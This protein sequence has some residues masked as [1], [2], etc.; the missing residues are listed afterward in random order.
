MTSVKTKIPI[1][2]GLWRDSN[3]PDGKPRLVGSECKNCGELFFPK[4]ENGTCANCQ[5]TDL[6]DVEF[7]TRGRVYS[8][9]VVMQRPPMYYQGEVPYALGFV[10]LPEGIRIETLFTECDF[11]RLEIG[12]DVEMVLEKLHEDSEGRE[13]ITYKFRPVTT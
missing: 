3:E 1:R 2:A 12:L 9:T 6:K 11:D 7:S 13:V 8:H 4:K 10:E 5:S